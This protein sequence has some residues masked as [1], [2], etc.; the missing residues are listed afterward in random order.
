[1]DNFT[2]TFTL[3]P[4]TGRMILNTPRAGLATNDKFTRLVYFSTVR[5]NT[6]I[7]NNSF[8]SHV[9][10]DLL[11]CNHTICFGSWSHHQVIHVYNNLFQ[12]I[13]LHLI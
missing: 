1:M 13:E 6:A 5:R 10:I 2:F 9:Q 11:K 3:T 4:F 12:I 7:Y 8:T